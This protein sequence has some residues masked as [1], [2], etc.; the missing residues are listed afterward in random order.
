MIGGA[1]GESVRTT[2]IL[3]QGEANRGSS[4]TI[5]RTGARTLWP[6]PRARCR[7]RKY[8]AFGREFLVPIPRGEHKCAERVTIAACG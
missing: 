7:P 1:D 4:V 6:H 2:E 8:S 3:Q 5:N